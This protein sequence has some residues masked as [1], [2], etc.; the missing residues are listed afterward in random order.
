MFIGEIAQSLMS[1]SP[2]E[3]SDGLQYRQYHHVDDIARAIAGQIDRPWDGVNTLEINGPE[4][5]RLIDLATAI[6]AHFGKSNLLRI[7]A[8]PTSEGDIL[9][10]PDYPATPTTLFPYV[11]P[12]IP[13]VVDWLDGVVAGG[14]L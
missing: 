13:G 4:T 10:P 11:R 12:T 6:Y 14:E 2:F 8:R 7:G 5:V 3:M 1:D 9:D